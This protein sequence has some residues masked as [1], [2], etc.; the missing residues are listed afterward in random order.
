M[1]RSPTPPPQQSDAMRKQAEDII[2]PAMAS[3]FGSSEFADLLGKVVEKK[4]KAPRSSSSTRSSTSKQLS[5]KRSASTEEQS[6]PKKKR[7]TVLSSSSEERDSDEDS[8][9]SPKKPK[10]REKKP[11][12]PT[13]AAP[14]VKE[15]SEYTWKKQ[16][17]T[18]RLRHAALHRIVKNLH[19][20]RCAAFGEEEEAEL[21][22]AYN[23]ILKGLQREMNIICIADGSPYGYLTTNELETTME[24]DDQ[25]L[26]KLAAKAERRIKE[27]LEKAEKNKQPFQDRAGGSAASKSRGRHP[28]Q[29]QGV[30]GQARQHELKCFSCQQTGHFQRSCPNRDPKNK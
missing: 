4:E 16:Q 22:G 21:I 12:K 2:G 1:S 24:G 14:T 28:F 9:D 23:D 5:K 8:D 13:W 10:K 29:Q 15:T 25:E 18:N 3:Y 27:R 6:K 11:A 19:T 20:F 30:A 7:V 17:P 26:I